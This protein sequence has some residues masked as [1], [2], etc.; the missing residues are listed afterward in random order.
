MT[1]HTDEDDTAKANKI[2]EM[3]RLMEQ[4]EVKRFVVIAAGAV[5]IRR[6]ERSVR[7]LAAD[8]GGSG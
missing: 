1:A 3:E 5:V 8:T 4:E 2:I 7:A 6:V